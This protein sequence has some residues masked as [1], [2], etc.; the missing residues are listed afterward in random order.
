MKKITS[1]I[2]AVLL[3]ATFAFAK[4]D[5]TTKKV[6]VADFNEL[7]CFIAC[8]IE[9][10]MGET[11]FSIYAPEDVHKH[12]VTSVKDGR[13]TITFDQ[14]KFYKTK[15]V[16]IVLSSRTLKYLDINASVEFEAPKGITS[17]SFVSNLNGAAELDIKGLV[18]K[19]VE[20]NA[21]G[22]TEVDIEGLEC[23][24][25]KLTVNGTGKADLLGKAKKADLTVNG[26][27]SIDIKHLEVE[28][29]NSSVHGIGSISKK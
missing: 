22:A 9:Y 25:L 6:T 12:L 29:L 23:D 4:D 8:E 16:K 14:T 21:N 17:S 11:S 24:N 5:Y 13:L 18:T 2:A 27:G 20:I 3:T 10:T 15:D 19:D 7:S 1:I 26:V 28:D